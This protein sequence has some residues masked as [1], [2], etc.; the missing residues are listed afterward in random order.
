MEKMY[1]VDST[2]KEARMAILIA[3]KIDKN[4]Y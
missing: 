2:Q 3:D 4:F 1:Y